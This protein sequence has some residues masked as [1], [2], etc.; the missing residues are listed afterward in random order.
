MAE[1]KDWQFDLDEYIRQG[2]PERVEKS[3]AWQIAIG[4]QQVDGLQTS[5]YLLDTAKEHIEG[6]ISIKQAQQR[7]RTYYEE[8][9]ERKEIE[10]GTEEADIVSSR[11]TELLGE[12]TFQ[13][14]PAELQ[15][16]HRRLFEGVFDYAGQIRTYNITKK[17]WV[18]NGQ[19]V[20]YASWNSIR[21]TLNYDF[22]MEKHFSY[23]GLSLQEAIR[24]LAKFTSDIWQIHPFCE[25]N[26][27]A[28]AVFI[29]KYIKTFGLK[30]DNE[31]FRSHSWYFRNALVRANYNDLRNGIHATTKYLE[32]FFSNLLLET[33]YELK[34]RYLHIDF[35]PEPLVQPIQ[36]AIDDASKGKICTLNCPLDE[37]AILKMIIENPN[38]TQKEL[39]KRIEKSERTIKSKIA[40][41]KEKGY[42]RRM[43]GKRNGK[44]EVLVDLNGAEI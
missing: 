17:E 6:K 43:N 24:H 37:L 11:I 33:H 2:E 4:L 29:I 31:A 38:I 40:S 15:N 5:A 9:A 36:S 8:Q 34:N 22:E 26:T 12:K 39:A 28:T 20:L 13:F 16:I 18:L 27:R 21:D 30:A 19:T 25:G 14:S 44:W 10:N 35:V 42:I 3:E 23:E 1:E 7:I 41:L 32:L